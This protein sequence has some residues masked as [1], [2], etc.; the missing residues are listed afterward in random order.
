[1][2][3]YL[4]NKI[5]VG[6]GELDQFILDPTIIELKAVKVVRQTSQATQ[7]FTSSVAAHDWGRF[8]LNFT[9]VKSL[10]L[11]AVF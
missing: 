1:M 6:F 11:F 4:Q 7:M 8:Y 5:I 10:A 9:K 3:V 2:S